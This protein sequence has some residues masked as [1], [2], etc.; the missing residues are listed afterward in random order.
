MSE[1]LDLTIAIPAKNEANIIGD[2]IKSIGTNF[3]KKII[4]IDSSSIDKTCEIAEELGAEVINFV[5]DGKF[6]K[7][8]NWYLRNHP[9]STKWILFLDADEFLTLNFKQEVKLKIL[10]NE[11]VGFWLSYSIYFAGKKLKGGYPLQ[12][13]ALF[14]VGLGEYERIKEHNW[15]KLDMEVHEHPILEGKIG[16]IKSRIDHR[17]FRSIEHYINK[18]SEYAKWESCRFIELNSKSYQNLTLKQKLKYRLLNSPWI[19]PLYFIGSFIFLGG[20]R[21]GSMG[22]TFAILKMAYF[23]EIYCRIKE[24]KEVDNKNLTTKEKHKEKLNS[25]ESVEFLNKNQIKKLQDLQH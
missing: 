12:K 18:Q 23:N 25:K 8:R 22:L 24:L 14:Q 2:C 13:L 15:S 9:P 11:F 7:K 10:K 17:D 1:P 19:G 4:V 6:P 3:C 5:W 20:F 21:D 16:T